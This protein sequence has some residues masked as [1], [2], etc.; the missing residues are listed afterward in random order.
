MINLT[1]EQL[2]SIGDD[3]LTEGRIGKKRLKVLNG[4]SGDALTA[5]RGDFFAKKAMSYF[6]GIAVKDS[7]NSTENETRFDVRVTSFSM[8]DGVSKNSDA[9]A[10]H[11]KNVIASRLFEKDGWAARS[12]EGIEVTQA[13]SGSYTVS[14][15]GEALTNY[16]E[17]KKTAEK[18]SAAAR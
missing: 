17:F 6:D 4:A 8:T 12:A 10:S 11:I 2:E 18:V 7:T 14:L 13:A 3:L 15:T 1:E 9:V 5:I 16:K